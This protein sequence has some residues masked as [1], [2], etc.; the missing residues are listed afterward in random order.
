MSRSPT[1]LKL[2]MNAI[3]KA[4][5]VEDPWAGFH[6]DSF[7]TEV[8]TRHRYN[9]LKKTWTSDDVLVKMELKVRCVK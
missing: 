4:K 5:S 2:W 1:K 7:E 3:N 8:C 6:I 9:A